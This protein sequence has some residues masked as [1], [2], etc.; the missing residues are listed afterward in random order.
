MVTKLHKSNIGL[1]LKPVVILLLISILAGCQNSKEK[2]NMFQKGTQVQSVFNPKIIEILSHE[3]GFEAPDIISSGWTTFR[4]KNMTSEPHF[5]LLQKYPDGIDLTTAKAEAS[6]VYDAAIKLVHAGKQQQGAAQLEK[7]PDWSRDV[8]MSG[9]LGLISPGKI[10]ETT[11]DLDPGL[12]IME[13]YLKTANGKF[14][15]DTRMI[16]ELRVEE[17][18]TENKE[19]GST[20]TI[21]ISSTGGI[22]YFGSIR[23]GKHVFAVDF[24]DQVLYENFVGHDVHLV[25]LK[26][27]IDI[28]ELNS[29]M[30]WLDP[31]AFIIPPP[32]GAEFLGGTQ[33]M[34][35]G[36][37][38]YF[39]ALLS[40]GKY[41]FISE[42]PDPMQKNMFKTF[43]VASYDSNRKQ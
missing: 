42:V 6:P 35:E 41:A 30:N 18:T 34:P 13:C 29:W 32:K 23:P 7:L 22:E 14:H 12:Y 19:P 27:N 8:L 1:N 21:S 28:S 37:T 26:E 31:N 5:L 9:G 25:R 2:E 24:K 43:T 4:Y 11:I 38:S 20:K 3:M 15:S 10:A 17:S 36:K 16:R 33:E 39:S 40:P